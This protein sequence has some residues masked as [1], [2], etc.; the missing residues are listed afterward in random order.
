M[1]LDDLKTEFPRERISWRAQSVTKDGMKGMALAYI[2]ARDVMNRLDEVCGPSGWQ[3]SYTIIEGRTICRLG[4]C[5]GTEREW[6]YKSDG[7]GETQFEGD[8]G[9][10][11]D[12]F[13]RAAVKWGIGRYLYDMPCPWVPCE[14]YKKGDKWQWRK[15]TADPWDYVG[16]A[17]MMIGPL[18]KTKLETECRKFVNDLGDCQDSGQLAGLQHDYETV[19]KQCREQHPRWWRGDDEQPGIQ[20]KIEEAAEKF[21]QQERTPLEAG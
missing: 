3:D 14:S 1:K 17:P 15:F 5:L 18:S 11:S 6:V 9:A 4:I 8:K 16:K 20:Q 7:A 12:A 13:K 10:M 2:D 21:D 19:L